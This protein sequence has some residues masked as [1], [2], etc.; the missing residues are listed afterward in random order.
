[1]GGDESETMTVKEPIPIGTKITETVLH[2]RVRGRIEKGATINVYLG[3]SEWAEFEARELR[4]YS[5]RHRAPY[6]DRGY[7][8]WQ[9]WRIFKVD[10][11]THFDVN[12]VAA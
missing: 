9:G 10:A 3:R 5:V 2:C 8:E 1:V 4:D 11:R 12:I 7:V 6:E